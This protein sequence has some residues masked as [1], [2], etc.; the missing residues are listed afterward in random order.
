MHSSIGWNFHALH[1][2][3]R[4][5]AASSSVVRRGACVAVAFDFELESGYGDRAADGPETEAVLLARS[6]AGSA[7]FVY[8][9]GVG[10]LSHFASV[11]LSTWL[12]GV[13]LAESLLLL[14]GAFVVA[15]LSDPL[16]CS[17]AAGAHHRLGVQ[18]DGATPARR[19]QPRALE[20]FGSLDN[21]FSGSDAAKENYLGTLALLPEVLK[22]HP[23]E[24]VLI[25]LPVELHY[26][27][28]SVS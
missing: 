6:S 12:A 14:L 27:R 10:H 5:A 4:N 17:P 26:R 15:G 1:Q 23:I 13:L 21:Q 19:E 8:F 11:Q 18:G 2:F 9:C 25:S 7:L 22:A 28:L 3:F 20:I 16:S 24:M